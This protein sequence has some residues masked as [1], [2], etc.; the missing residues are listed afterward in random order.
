MELGEHFVKSQW[1]IKNHR[2]KANFSISILHPFSCVLLK[3]GNI[4][5][6]KTPLLMMGFLMWLFPCLKWGKILAIRM[7][8]TNALDP[9][10]TEGP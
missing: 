7:G 9:Q 10:K 5:A 6:K 1:G 4:F 8:F 3:S 2:L